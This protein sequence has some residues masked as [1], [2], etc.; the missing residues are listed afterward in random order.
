MK[1]KL[2]LKCNEKKGGESY[3]MYGEEFSERR[4]TMNKKLGIL[5]FV[6]V[7]ALCSVSVIQAGEYTTPKKLIKEATAQIKEVSIH[8]VKKMI[9]NKEDVI[10]LDIRDP[11]EYEEKGHIPGAIHMSRGLLDLHVQEII[12]DK[13]AK[14][15]VY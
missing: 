2:I 5:F 10:I 8:D 7:F 3:L 11:A 1:E 9:D 14:I 15:V 4:K 12:P 6:V 13:N